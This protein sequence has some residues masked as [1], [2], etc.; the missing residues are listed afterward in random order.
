[1]LLSLLFGRMEKA[2]ATA[3][4]CGDRWSSLVA[5]AALFAARLPVGVAMRGI[6]IAAVGAD[7]SRVIRHRH[8]PSLSSS[9]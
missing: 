8:T 2:L 6:G 9:A 4:L 5:V 1:M 7:F 3:D